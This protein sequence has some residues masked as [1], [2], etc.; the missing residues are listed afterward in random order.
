[1]DRGVIHLRLFNR[2]NQWVPIEQE[3]KISISGDMHGGGD[4]GLV[5][6]FVRVLRGQST[7]PGATRIE[8]SLNGHLIAYAADQA[9]LTNQVVE[10]KR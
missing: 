5:E 3:I 1:M 4:M 10:I 6:D 7:S 8:D 9:M 2:E